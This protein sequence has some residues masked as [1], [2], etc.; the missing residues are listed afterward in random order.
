MPVWVLRCVVSG[1]VVEWRDK[2]MKRM[3]APDLWRA[4]AQQLNT[5]TDMCHHVNA[6]S[7]TSPH[8]C[9]LTCTHTHT[10]SLTY[11]RF[12]HAAQ[13]PDRSRHARCAPNTLVRLHSCAFIIYT[14][15]KCA[16]MPAMVVWIRLASPSHALASSRGAADNVVYAQQ[17]LP[18]LVHHSRCSLAAAA[19]LTSAAS[20]ADDTT[21]RLSL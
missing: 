20:E 4:V 12:L 16:C 6:P 21:A 8:T 15:P 10:H 17:E 14:L 13:C 7:T 3:S 19:S 11:T 2:D 18:K 1:R 5:C 9:T